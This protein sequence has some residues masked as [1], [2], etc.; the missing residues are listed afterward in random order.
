LRYRLEEVVMPQVIRCPECERSLRV[1]D[2]LLGKMVRCPS[3]K[4]TFTAQADEEIEP[5]IHVEDSPSKSQRRALESD[6]EEREV[7]RPRRDDLEDEESGRGADDEYEDDEGDF[8][9]RRRR[10]K[11]RKGSRTEWRK[12]RSG[13]TLVISGVFAQLAAILIIAIGLFALLGSIRDAAHVPGGGPPTGG[14]LVIC[15]AGILALTSLILYV[16]GNIFCVYVPPL[17][18]AR[19]LAITSLVLLCA[20]LLLAC[21]AG[22]VQASAGADRARPPGTGG[23]PIGLLGNLAGLAQIVVFIFFMRQSALTLG[24]RGLARSI[25]FLLVYSVVA[26]VVSV[27]L[28]LWL[29]LTTLSFLFGGE[30]VGARG[31]AFG[32][33]VLAVL[34]IVG[35][36]LLGMFIWY[37][38]SLFQLRGAITRYVEY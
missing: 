4:A 9:E 17:N 34:I 37:V 19:T 38:V 32:G 24:E 26:V 6:D 25:V 35:L 22:I 3:C 8:E 18:G 33:S 11:K 36:L 27:A 30:N 7:R 13:I 28:I 12:V 14:L 21:I 1:P 20:N 29:I 5:Q 23:N 10:R 2:D 16:I 31:A 15:F